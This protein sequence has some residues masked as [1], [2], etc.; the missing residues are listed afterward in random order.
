MDQTDSENIPLSTHESTPRSLGLIAPKPEV[1][2]LN[3]LLRTFSPFERLLLYTF[4]LLLGISAFVLLADVNRAVS[5]EVPTHGGSLTEGAV[6]VP[7]FI[8]P[9]LALTQ[10][11]LDLT[12]LVYSGLLRTAHASSTT[13]CNASVR[14]IPDLAER[15]DISADGT[16]Y[17]FHLRRDLTFHDGTPL[18]SADVLFTIELAQNPDI[19]SPRRADWEGVNVTTPDEYTVVFT[20]PHAYGPF[21]ENL[22]LG[23]VPKHLWENVPASEFAFSSLNTHPVGSGPY[24]IEESVEDSTGAPIEYRLRAFRNF[25]LGEANLTWFVYKTYANEAELFAAYDAHDIESF[26]APSPKNVSR[27]VAE[28]ASLYREALARVFGVFLNQ[29]HAPILAK[30]EVR[31]AL[32]A[33]IDR[34]AIIEK[35]LHGYGVPAEG[36]IPPG[37]LPVATSASSTPETI[38]PEDRIEYARSFLTKAGWSYDAGANTWSKDSQKLA[39]TLATVDTEDLVATAQAVADAWN[40]VGITTSV[41]IYP[42]QEFNTTILRP[43]AY[44]AILFGEVVGRS[45][46]LFA[47]WHSSQR[48]DPGLN[49]AL[50]TSPSADKELASARDEIESEKREAHLLE[51]ARILSLDIPAVFLY[52]PLIAYIVPQEVNGVTIETLTTPSDRLAHVYTWYRDTERVWNIFTE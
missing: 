39:L 27:A 16:V 15:Y 25:A 17:T 5:T 20:L 48:N 18:T 32:N 29:N 31:A 44:D 43:R 36:P 37:L 14:Y 22:T 9:L 28:N 3:T 4:T 19:K 12:A 23:I 35:V 50:Y 11:D 1:S 26:V 24:R 51:F 42:L 2:G 7:R 47:F 10:P 45:L 34:N 38:I 13:Q 52:T 40:A 33:A 41:Q 30:S 21:R 6:G 49:L 8:N 46:D